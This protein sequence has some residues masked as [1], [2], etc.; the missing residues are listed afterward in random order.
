MKDNLQDLIK[1][2]YG[3]GVVET[4]KVE[5]TDK[6]TVITAIGEDRSVIV[7]GTF[8]TVLPEFEGVFGMCNLNKLKTILSFEEY[9]DAAKINMVKNKDGNPISIHFENKNGDFVNDYRGLMAKV[10]IEDRVKLPVMKTPNW[11]VEIEPSMINIARLKKQA[12]ANN[13]EEYFAVKTDGTDL[14]LYFGNPSSHSGN[15]VFHTD[16]K[17][18]LAHANKYPIKV[19]LAILDLPGTKTLRISDRGAIE[20]VVNSGMTVY[21]Y[22]LPMQVNR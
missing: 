1:Y 15:L 16:V 6:Q 8:N 2:A 21:S 4:I 5:G 13:D 14:R 12:I 22:K 7:Q 18:T 19:F 3:L 20:I 10:I 11:D 9:D 17:G